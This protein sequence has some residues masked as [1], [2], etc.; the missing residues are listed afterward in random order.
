MRIHSEFRALRPKGAGVAKLL[1]GEEVFDGGFARVVVLDN[2][3][4]LKAT[5]CAATNLLFTE[6]RAL[7]KTP[8]AYPEALPAVMRD[9]GECV[10][11]QDG[12]HYRG[13]EVERLFAPEQTQDMSRARTC[14]KGRLSATKPG[15][16]RRTRQGS[17]P[18]HEQLN[19]A[20]SR[21][22]SILPAA[23]SDWRACA[24]LASALAVC[25][26][27]PVREGFLFLEDF[28][29][30]HKLQLDLLT[31]GNLMLDMFGQ[32]VLSDPVTEPIPMDFLDRIHDEVEPQ[33][34]LVAEVPVSLEPELRTKLQYR[35]TFGLSEQ[36]LLDAR[37]R[38]KDLGIEAVALAT[39]N[40]ERLKLLRQA[41]RLDSIWCLPAVAKNLRVN[42][43]EKAIL[44]F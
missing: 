36:A 43:Y 22:Q 9:Y 8:N 10:Y 17:E 37:Q 28:V 3:T 33:L 24:D 14:G 7:A 44:G 6:L 18:I 42:A 16:A 41:P 23:G 2:Y 13:W 30:R 38:L 35:S 31:R 25:T 27:G 26:D 39:D 11:D 1:N 15:Y 40:P 32:P 20:I 12:I 21:E 19:A 29:R 34:T 4:V 5:S